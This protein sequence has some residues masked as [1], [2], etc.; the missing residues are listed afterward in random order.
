MKRPY[1]EPEMDLKRFLIEEAITTSLTGDD[2][3][4]T[5]NASDWTASDEDGDEI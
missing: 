4:Q 5:G 1:L 3:G 2:L